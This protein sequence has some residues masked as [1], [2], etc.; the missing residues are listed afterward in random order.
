MIWKDFQDILLSGKKEESTKGVSTVCYPL[1]MKDRNGGKYVSAHLCKRDT[2]RN[3]AVT[4]EHGYF[5]VASGI[6]RK[7]G[8]MGTGSKEEGSDFL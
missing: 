7:M 6:G 5:L 4:N 2:G 8:G 3:K 1:C